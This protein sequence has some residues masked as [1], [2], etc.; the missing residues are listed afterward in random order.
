MKSRKGFFK[1]RY[2]WREL[3][4]N[5]PDNTK[6]EVYNA[7]V[8][9]SEHGNVVNLST[10]GDYIFNIIKKDIDESTQKSKEANKTDSPYSSKPS[11]QEIMD[12]CKERNN[13]IDAQ[14]FF[15]FYEARGW[16][17]GKTKIKDWKACIRTW[18]RNRKQNGNANGME[19]GVILKEKPKYTKGW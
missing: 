3:I 10:M 17:Y 12:Y 2:V 11:I 15:D 14:N 1:F 8:E 9:Y 5:L 4:D 18:E 13:G 19:I 7:I 6:L 16:C